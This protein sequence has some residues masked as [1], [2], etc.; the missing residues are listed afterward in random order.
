VTN[1]SKY[2]L[3]TQEHDTD[4][5][6]ETKLYKGDVLQTVTGGAPVVFQDIE[7]LKQVSPTRSTSISPSRKRTSTG[8]R[9]P[10]KNE[11][12]RR[13]DDDAETSLTMR[14]T[15]GIGHNNPIKRSR[16]N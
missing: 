11:N 12:G 10:R 6:L 2:C 13:E 16:N 8:I 5:E 3:K 7:I 14:C 1:T 4:G 15:M 9:S